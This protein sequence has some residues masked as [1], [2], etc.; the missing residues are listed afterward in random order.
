MSKQVLYF[1]KNLTLRKILTFQAAQADST[2]LI[3]ANNEDI[4]KMRPMEA[5]LTQKATNIIT[6]Q[7]SR[8]QENCMFLEISWMFGVL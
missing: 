3:S 8:A 5:M 4:G 1:R 7:S 2:H 6:N